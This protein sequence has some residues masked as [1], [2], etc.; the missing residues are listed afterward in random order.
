MGLVPPHSALQLPRERIPTHSG[1]CLSAASARPCVV[2]RLICNYDQAPDSTL[3]KGTDH[4]LSST[5]TS[6]SHPMRRGWEA[7]LSLREVTL[8]LSDVS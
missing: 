7:R 6:L 2:S 3:R 8:L 4:V 5:G 1:H